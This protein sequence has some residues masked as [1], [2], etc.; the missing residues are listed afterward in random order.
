MFIPY[1]L[2]WDITREPNGN[3]ELTQFKSL[4]ESIND[5]QH[6]KE[7]DKWSWNLV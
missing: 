5:F 3:V 4:I 1:D 7:L 2:I 6:I